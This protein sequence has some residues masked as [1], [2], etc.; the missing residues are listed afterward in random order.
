MEIIICERCGRRC[1]TSDATE[2]DSK[3]IRKSTA[4]KGLCVDCAITCFIKTGLMSAIPPA[5]PISGILGMEHI[6]QQFAAVFVAAKCPGVAAEINWDRV[7]ANWELG[8][9][10]K[11]WD[12]KGGLYP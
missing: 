8:L 9:P 5:Y 2:A 6:Q 10:K 4:P 11:G 1:Q 7:I 3:L 12:W